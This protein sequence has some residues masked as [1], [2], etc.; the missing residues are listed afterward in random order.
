[1]KKFIVSLGTLFYCLFSYSQ[2]SLPI[3][4]LKSLDGT[5]VSTENLSEKDEV[6]VILLWATWCVPCINELDAIQEN[7]ADWQ[8]ETNFKLIA[9]SIDNARTSSRVKPLVNGKEWGYEILL[10]TNQD[11]KRAVNANTV[12]YVLI[13][14]NNKIVYS[15]IGYTP[16]S[17]IDLYEKVK[18]SAQ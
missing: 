11:F 9:I 6:L 13:V 10:D 15:H 4:K 14:K 18:E 3:L 12:P 7:Y 1:M 17:E 2:N 5:I 8:E 16:G